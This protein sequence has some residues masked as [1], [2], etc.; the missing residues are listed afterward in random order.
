MDD[1]NLDAPIKISDVVSPNNKMFIS[2][3]MNT[4]Q[5]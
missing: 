2:T 4:T 3:T 5:N 1:V